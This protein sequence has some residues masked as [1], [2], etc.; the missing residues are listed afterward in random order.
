MLLFPTL[1]LLVHFLKISSVDIECPPNYYR[2]NGIMYDIINFSQDCIIKDPFQTLYQKS[3]FISDKSCESDEKC[4]GTKSNPFDSF[5]KALIVLHDVDLAEQYLEQKVSFLLLGKRHWMDYYENKDIIFR[6]FRRFNASIEIRPFFCDEEEIDGCLMKDEIVDLMIKSDNFIFEVYRELNISNIR[7]LGNDIV[8]NSDVTNKCWKSK[9]LCCE[10]HN[11]YNSTDSCYFLDKLFVITEPNKKNTLFSMITI[12]SFFDYEK[13]IPTPKLNLNN[14]YLTN[15]YGLNN[16]ASFILFNEM[17][18]VIN[19]EQCYFY[20]NAF[21]FGYFYQLKLIDDPYYQ[22]FTLIPIFDKFFPNIFNVS[23]IYINNYN[24]FGVKENFVSGIFAMISLFTF[25]FESSLEYILK[26]ANISIQNNDFSFLSAGKITFDFGKSSNI[27]AIIDFRGLLFMNNTAM[28]LFNL[29]NQKMEVHDFLII[30]NTQ[31]IIKIIDVR[32]QSYLSMN[33]GVIS[34]S[35]YTNKIIFMACSLSFIILNNIT[36]ENIFDKFLIVEDQSI[37]TIN[38]SLIHKVNVSKN[39]IYFVDSKLYLDHIIFIDVLSLLESGYVF[40]FLSM[41]N[42]FGLYFTNSV[43]INIEAFTIFEFEA[44]KYFSSIYFTNLEFSS[45][46]NVVKK[47]NNYHYCF[48]ADFGASV[49][50]SLIM[51]KIFIRD[52]RALQLL[53]AGIGG[54]KIFINDITF[55]NFSLIQYYFIVIGY[56]KYFNGSLVVMNNLKFENLNF[57]R[58]IAIFFLDYFEQIEFSNVFFSNLTCSQYLYSLVSTDM[59]VLEIYRIK[60]ANLNSIFFKHNNFFCATVTIY[61]GDIYLMKFSNSE[62]SSLLPSK[63]IRKFNAFVLYYF[64]YAIF[65]NNTISGMSTKENPYYVREETGIISILG[66]NSY[67]P[68]T[69]YSNLYF[70]SMLF[71]INYPNKFS[72]FNIF[73][74]NIKLNFIR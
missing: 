39:F 11:F 9:V 43:C 62:I 55:R 13:N 33:N 26:M 36:F 50:N 53:Y 73:S 12:R 45:M 57:E 3:F 51:E 58:K 66:T 69:T 15:T 59:F 38:Y 65:E 2:R 41:N 24:N 70:K 32:N 61:M 6:F 56:Y 22:K 18:Y 10:E 60:F 20:N 44:Y 1:F 8:L 29:N 4:L 63:N 23:S 37:L 42:V 48:L 67:E 40:Y 19:L 25:S 49:L 72:I 71:L 52:S 74:K 28:S 54:F 5:M 27:N 68:D 35:K 47:A 64:T 30:N 17:N 34:G 16:W 31:F 46:K 21:G 7:I 14:F